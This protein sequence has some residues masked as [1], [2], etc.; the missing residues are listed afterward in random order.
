MNDQQL[1]NFYKVDDF[2]KGFR[3]K[4]DVVV[5]EPGVAV[6]GSQNIHVVDNTKIGNRPGFSYLG[7]RS[8]NTNGIGGGGSWKT[9]TATELPLR[10]YHD[11][12]NGFL[13]Y[14]ST[15]SSAWEVII[16]T[17]SSGDARFLNSGSGV[18]LGWWD[19]TEVEDLLLF[20][21]G[22]ANIHMWSGGV[23][24]YASATSTTLTKQGTNTWAEDRYL[25]AGTRQVR[26][27]DDSDVWQTF[28]YTGGEGT[29]TLTGV[30]PDPT[31]QSLTA[32]ALAVQA[33]RSTANTPAAAIDNDF[34]GLY[35]NYLFTFDKV[36]KS[37]E[38]SSN[39]DYTSFAS[40]T[41]PRLPGEP[42]DFTLDEL[43]TAVITQPD[44][45]ALYISTKNQWYQ[46]VFTVSDD[47]SK[48]AI[49]IKPLK[50]SPL[51]GATNELAVTNMKNYTVYTSGEPTIDNLGRVENIDT[52][53]SVPLS[54]PIKNYVDVA[55]FT[56]SAS[57]YYKNDFYISLRESSTDNAN[58]RILIR[59]L[60]LGSWEAP[61]TIPSSVIFEYN[62][63]LYAHDPSTT[64][65]YKLLDT[66]YSDNYVS[67]AVQAPI[68]AKWFSSHHNYGYPYNLKKFNMFWIDGY[69]RANTELDILFTYDF[70][71]ETKKYTLKGL[72]SGVVIVE[73]GGGLGYF[74]LGSRNLGGAGQTLAATGLRRFRGFIPV[75]E[76]PFYE[77]QV[78]FQSNGAG[79]RWEVAGYGMNINAIKAQDNT[80]KIDQ[81]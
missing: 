26:I 43:P 35:Q 7:A 21:T 3:A 18:L 77:L 62:G 67:E 17:L 65:T 53:Q 81:T 12:S 73:L 55:G 49:T 9:S 78:S 68:S 13:E 46:F 28:T 24:T 71:K 40:P 30:T 14:Y 27:K 2:S 4:T 74:S 11:G 54:D 20:V 75:P 76:R 15:V 16:G 42:S 41:S 8:T 19:S 69:I 36:S 80:L 45:D 37:I 34:I 5:E 39:T 29:T 57:A 72:D 63:D 22:D 70:S 56:T 47:N 1:K 31:A 61:W 48:E 33:A 23:T 50:S 32:G 25:T 79:E 64:N 51:E 60:R 38:M 58:N 44:G 59:N 10:S 52:P 66:N 6:D